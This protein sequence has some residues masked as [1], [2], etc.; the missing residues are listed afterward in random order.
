[1]L[2]VAITTHNRRDILLN[3]LTHW[4]EHTPADVPIVVV[5]DGSFAP[6]SLAGLFDQ[7]KVVRH[8]QPRGIAVAKNR[9]IAELMDLWCDHLFL[10]DDDVWPTTDEW[11]KP[12]IESPEP[13]LSFQWPSGGRHSVTHQDEQHFATSTQHG[14]TFPTGK[15]KASRTTS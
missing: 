7:V 5:D 9:C 12:Y 4:T 6:L 14:P 15:A 1:M 13:H 11:W 3:A 2:G 8:P 10:A